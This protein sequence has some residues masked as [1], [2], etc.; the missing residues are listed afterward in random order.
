MRS[1]NIKKKKKMSNK[2]KE[3]IT[4]LDGATGDIFITEYDANL[5]DQIEDYFDLINEEHELDLH[6]GECNWMVT[7]ETNIRIL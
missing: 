4:I 2:T 7:E 1:G 3:F 5:V 6:P